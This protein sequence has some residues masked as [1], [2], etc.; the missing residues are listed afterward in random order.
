[1]GAGSAIC[2][3]NAKAAI[4]CPLLRSIDLAMAKGM[5]VMINAGISLMT[6]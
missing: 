5:V 2:L 4:H 3:G 1:L 6:S